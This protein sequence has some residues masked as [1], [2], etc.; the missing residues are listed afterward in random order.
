MKTCLKCGLEK[1]L[2]SFAKRSAS[3][4]GLYSYCRQCQKVYNAA[5][6]A[7]KGE[8][9][10]E[11]VKAYN[12]RVGYYPRRQARLR[13]ISYGRNTDNYSRED[14]I[15]RDNS[16]C[17]ICGGSVEPRD[18]TLDHVIPLAL[19]GDDIASNVKVAHRECNRRKGSKPLEN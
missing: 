7:R 19:G 2:A 14:I 18:L 16:I 4:D 8:E 6:Y 15:R 17:H 12:A 13:A 10:R 5:Q 11:Q 3:K 9:M 1:P